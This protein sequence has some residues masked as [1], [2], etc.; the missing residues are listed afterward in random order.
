M[1]TRVKLLP[2]ILIAL[3]LAANVALA[4]DE[5]PEATP[6]V[7]A[8][9]AET[10]PELTAEAAPEIIEEAT[11]E[12]VIIAPVEEATPAAGST[13][14][15]AAEDAGAEARG[16]PLGVLLIGAVAV[17]LIGTVVLIREN[18]RPLEDEE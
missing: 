6:S 9:V 3:L 13:P 2:M 10:T 1:H 7:Q 5:T 18:P 4:Q 16:L 14:D 12:P 11:V 17:L 8:P 15:A